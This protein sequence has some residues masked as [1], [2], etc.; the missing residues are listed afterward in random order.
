MTGRNL[1]YLIRIATYLHADGG[2]ATMAAPSRVIVTGA[3]QGIGRAVALRTAA[4]GAHVAVWDTQADGAEETAR[5]CRERARS[6]APGASTSAP[7]TRSKP[8]WRRSSGNGASLTGWSTMPVFFRARGRSTW[9]SPSGS[10]V[11]RVNLTGTFLC[12]RAVA[13]VDER[14][15]PRRHRQHGIRPGARRRRERRALFRIEGRASSR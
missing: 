3:A 15:R 12:A 10:S 2:E 7:P 11:L 14:S 13:R 5:L 1:C 8:R 6:R 9:R 4:T